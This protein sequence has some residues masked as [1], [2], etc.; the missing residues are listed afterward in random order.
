MIKITYNE[1]PQSIFKKQAD[2]EALIKWARPPN[3]RIIPLSEKR[4][5]LKS[6][7]KG[8]MQRH[9]IIKYTLF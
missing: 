2:E 6:L 8:Y 9:N 7:S 1:S 3:Q 5:W 4:E